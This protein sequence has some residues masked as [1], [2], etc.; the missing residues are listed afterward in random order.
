[1][2]WFR[3]A[4]D[5]GDGQAQFALGGIYEQGELVP[6]DLAQARN[7]YQKAAAQQGFA[8]DDARQALVR[9]QGT[10]LP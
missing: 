6:K 10:A 1:L 8:Q 7:W 5:L 3:R 2:V 9:L 4:A